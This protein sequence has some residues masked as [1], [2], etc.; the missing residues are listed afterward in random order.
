MAGAMVS[1]VCVS[2]ALTREIK[3]TK[4]AD[5]ADSVDAIGQ[6]NWVV[7]SCSSSC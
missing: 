7:P 4:A 2:C 6:T 3:E 1:K 5:V